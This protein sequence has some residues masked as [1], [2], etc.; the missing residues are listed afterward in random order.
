MVLIVFVAVHIGFSL[1]NKS[2]IDTS[3]VTVVV[4]DFVVVVVAIV[5]H[6]F[7]Y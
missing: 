6:C 3:L 4:V 5:G 2:L 7:C 1:F